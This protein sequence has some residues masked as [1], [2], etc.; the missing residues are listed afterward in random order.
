M[1][2]APERLAI[3]GEARKKMKCLSGVA[4]HCRKSFVTTP[5]KRICPNC[6]T[7]LRYDHYSAR[8]STGDMELKK[9]WK[10]LK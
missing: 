1:N 4:V 10:S 2:Q 7:V 9:F 6:T 3:R 5:E 8:E